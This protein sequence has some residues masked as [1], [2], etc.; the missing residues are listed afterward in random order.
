MVLCVCYC[1]YWLAVNKV[2]TSQSWQL[3]Q[4]ICDLGFYQL[5]FMYSSRDVF[6]QCLYNFLLVKLEA[7][8]RTR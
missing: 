7:F 1:K 3:G 5:G 2:A 6:M 4:N 8:Y